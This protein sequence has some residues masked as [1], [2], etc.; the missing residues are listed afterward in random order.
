MYMVQMQPRQDPFWHILSILFLHSPYLLWERRKQAAKQHINWCAE[1]QRSQRG[2]RTVWGASEASRDAPL[3]SSISRMVMSVRCSLYT[4][5]PPAV[6]CCYLPRA[7]S[8]RGS[9]SSP[10]P[11]CRTSPSSRRDRRSGLEMAAS[12][13]GQKSPGLVL[14]C[15]QDR[16]KRE[17]SSDQALSPPIHL[18]FHPLQG[19]GTSRSGVHSLGFPLAFS[20]HG[21]GSH[22]RTRGLVTLPRSGRKLQAWTETIS[23][24]HSMPAAW[25]VPDTRHLFQRLYR[26]GNRPG[27]ELMLC[28]QKPQVQWSTKILEGNHSSEETR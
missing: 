15:F 25:H 9:R 12:V 19:Q 5:T 22:N 8:L 11:W 28:T 24:L 16:N 2:E 10:P 21:A 1:P 18:F 6:A 27:Q 23:V 4:N 17:K 3:L 13:G 14:L 26:E 20:T 7:G